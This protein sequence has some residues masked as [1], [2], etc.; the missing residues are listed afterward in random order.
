MNLHRESIDTTHVKIV[1]WFVLCDPSILVTKFVEQSLDPTEVLNN[2]VNPVV[3]RESWG[4]GSMR[5]KSHPT[6]ILRR[7][8]VGRLPAKSQA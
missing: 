1:A 6:G 8:F 3:K 2:E 5:T 4:G 7:P